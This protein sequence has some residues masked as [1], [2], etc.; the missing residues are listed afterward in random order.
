MV[1]TTDAYTLIAGDVAAAYAGRG[2]NIRTG[3]W[4]T[5]SGVNLSQSAPSKYRLRSADIRVQT[6]AGNVKDGVF[7]VCFIA[8][9]PVHTDWVVPWFSGVQSKGKLINW[10]GDIPMGCG[11]FWRIHQGGLIA[12]DVVS[13]GVSYE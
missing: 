13:L 9:D 11:F 3:V 12:T 1:W 4:E 10:Q 5:V 6:A 8:G 2:Y 7:I